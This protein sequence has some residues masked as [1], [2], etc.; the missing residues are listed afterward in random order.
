MI[1]KLGVLQNL[2]NMRST[3]GEELGNQ[4]AKLKSKFVRLVM[5]GSIIDEQM[6]VAALIPSPAGHRQYNATVASVNTVSDEMPFWTLVSMIFFEENNRCL[7]TEGKV[8]S[9]VNSNDA[10]VIG[11]LAW[12]GKLNKLKQTG[13]K[14]FN[15][16][17]YNCNQIWHLRRN[18]RK[19]GA[20]V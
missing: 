15:L 7:K 13:K 4:I 9:F 19:K 2:L 6:K 11:I 3:R 16:R 20:V 14:V 5:M 1:I 17:C 8:L 18:C 12:S 10:E